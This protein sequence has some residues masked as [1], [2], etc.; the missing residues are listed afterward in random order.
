MNT[1]I[2]RAAVSLCLLTATAALSQ[3]STPIVYPAKNQSA[4]QQKKDEGECHTWAIQTTGIDP[5]APP[6]AATT[7]AQPAEPPKQQGGHRVRGAARGAA[8]GAIVGEIANDDA[9]EG[10]AVGAAVGAVSGGRQARKDAKASQQQAAQAQQQAQADAKAAEAA[11]LD[12]FNRAR[13]ACLEG[14]G[15]VIK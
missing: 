13:A 10:A 4:E 7:A 6:P 8:A 15:Y 14:R 5:A 1:H 12:T 11:R 9:S 3:N 2:L